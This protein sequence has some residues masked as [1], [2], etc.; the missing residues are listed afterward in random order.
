MRGTIDLGLYPRQ[1]GACER[2]ATVPVR[3]AGRDV[4]GIDQT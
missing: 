3:I 2:A 4:V 1:N